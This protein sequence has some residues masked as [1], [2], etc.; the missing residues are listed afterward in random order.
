MLLSTK[1]VIGCSLENGEGSVG[2]AHD[3]FFNDESWVVRYLV[4]STGRW[5]SGRHVLLPPTVVEQRDWPNRRLWVPLT[6]QQMGDS[7]E[8]D[9][10]KSVSRQ[11]ELELDRYPAW[12]AW[13]PVGGI[14]PPIARAAASVAAL[15]QEAEDIEGDSHLRSVS[16]VTGYHIEAADGSVGHVEELIMDDEGELHGPW[17]IRYLVVDTRNWLPGRKV[18]VAPCWAESISWDER[19]VRVDLNRQQIKDA[20]QYDP[21]VPINRRFE[22]ILFDYYGRPRYWIGHST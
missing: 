9:T 14:V 19:K 5:L 17:E 13:T 1:A 3:L 18:L 21:D 12:P 8:V 16:E 22:E 15:S 4:V 10:E 2:T 11:K 20:P 7:P 6:Q